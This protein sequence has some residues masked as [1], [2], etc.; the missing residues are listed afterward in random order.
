M[1]VLKFI[2]NLGRRFER[3]LVIVAGAVA[4]T[5]LLLSLEFSLLEANLYDLRMA[6]GSQPAADPGIVLITL[7]EQTTRELNEFSPLPL[8]L[9]AKLL[10]SLENAELKALGYLVD[11]NRV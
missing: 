9:H 8:D 1:E 5:S 4:L 6:R 10:E 11:F 7:D 2:Q 3:P